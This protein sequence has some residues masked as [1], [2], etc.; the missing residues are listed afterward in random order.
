VAYREVMQNRENELVEIGALGTVRDVGAIV[1]HFGTPDH[2]G[3]AVRAL[4]GVLSRARARD[5]IW[6]E[7]NAR[8]VLGSYRYYGSPWDRLEPSQVERLPRAGQRLATFHAN[9][10]VREAAVW[11]LASTSDADVLPYLLF[12]ANDWVVQVSDAA[13]FALEQ[14]LRP[15]DAAAWITILPFERHVWALKRRALAY[16]FDR[17]RHFLVQPEA[18]AAV[19]KA[20]AAG[21]TET[22]RACAELAASFPESEREST[23]RVAV[24]DRDPI[25][26]SVAARGLLEH[27]SDAVVRE[28]TG[29]LLVH[30]VARVR[31]QAL[32]SLS[33]RAPGE[34]FGALRGALFDPARC[35]REVAQFELRR[36]CAADAVPFYVAALPQARGPRRM[37]TIAGLAE[38]GSAEHAALVAPL[39]HDPST[40]VRFEALRAL[41]RLDGDAYAPAFLDA[42]D[43]ASPRVVRIAREALGRRAHLVDRARLDALLAAGGRSA[44]EALL[45]LPQVDYWGALLASLRAAAVPELRDVAVEVI[46]RLVGRHPSSAPPDHAALGR[47]LAVVRSDL[48]C[49]LHETV[50]GSRRAC[51]LPMAKRV[52]DLLKLT[53]PGG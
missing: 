17:A 29:P 12:R 13:R 32:F 52:A 1:Q 34:A 44:R 19:R 26:A 18:R 50:W 43:D 41:A 40:R 3:D 2:W 37:A 21:P 48:P 11:A 30:P 28:I 23:L 7:A 42:L 53:P 14:R 6:L 39:L 20:L 4:D 49:G 10:R 51:D 27:G 35:V 24:W 36:R 45:L 16:L 38:C 33:A 8:S 25:V 47:A 15:A 9:G 31:A 46:E 22:R 5:L